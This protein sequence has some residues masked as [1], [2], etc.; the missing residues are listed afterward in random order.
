MFVAMLCFCT[1]FVQQVDDANSKKDM[2]K[3]ENHN[4]R[5]ALVVLTG[6]YQF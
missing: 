2:Q 1:S 4:Q 5:L 3:T 6:L